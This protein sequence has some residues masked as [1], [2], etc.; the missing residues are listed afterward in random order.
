M[1]HDRELN[2]IKDGR[3]VTKEIGH[4]LWE[5]YYSYETDG[6]IEKLESRVTYL[7]NILIRLIGG[8]CTDQQVLEL[9]ELSN[10][11]VVDEP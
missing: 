9:L 8:V 2:L 1:F 6:V 10:K 5:N 11:Y 4:L 3:G 7:E